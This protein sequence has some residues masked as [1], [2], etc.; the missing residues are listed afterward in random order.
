MLADM[1]ERFGVEVHAF[2]LM[3]NHYHLVV[4]TPEPNLSDAMRWLQV[5]YTS[6]INWAHRPVGHLFQGRFK[7]ILIEVLKGVV[8][9]ARYVRLNPVRVGRLGL[10][11]A[12]QQRSRVV[13]G[14]DPGEESVTERL[15]T[16]RD[17]PWSSWR[18]YYGAEPKPGWLETEVIEMGCGGRSRSVG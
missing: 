13:G 16:V 18:V 4:R 9:V 14:V 10:G 12:E 7:A 1:S 15:K 11:K 8:E 5:T 6:R 3:D 2:V 17:Y